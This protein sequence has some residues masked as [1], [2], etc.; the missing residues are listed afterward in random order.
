MKA[1]EG[2]SLCRKLSKGYKTMHN[3]WRI[4]T[5]A[6]K[7][8]R[9]SMQVWLQRTVGCIALSSLVFFGAN[10]W[11]LLGC[12]TGVGIG[13]R[14]FAFAMY[15]VGLAAPRHKTALKRRGTILNWQFSLEEE[16]LS[17]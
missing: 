5:E 9:S 10:L 1:T 4:C 6:N 16:S 7:E 14:V 12:A 13:V 8:E 15:R 2:I 3:S 11:G 17:V